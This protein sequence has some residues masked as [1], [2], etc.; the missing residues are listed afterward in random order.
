MSDQLSGGRDGRFRAIAT[1]VHTRRPLEVALLS[2]GGYASRRTIPEAAV[3]QLKAE[4]AASREQYQRGFLLGHTQ[5]HRVPHHT[6]PYA[7]RQ[8]LEQRLGPYA[9]NKAKWKAVVA[10][11]YPYLLLSGYRG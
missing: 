6:M 8:H 5:R 3:D 2:G 1:D 10:S 7:L 11:E 4:A 9:E